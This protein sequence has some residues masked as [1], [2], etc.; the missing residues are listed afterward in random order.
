MASLADMELA[1]GNAETAVRIGRELMALAQGTRAGQ[2]AA[3]ERVNLCAAY[4]AL[5]QVDEALDLAR[6]FWPEAGRLVARDADQIA[7]A[8]REL[9]TAP[10]KREAVAATVDRFSWEA[11]TAGL[12]AHLMRL[13]EIRR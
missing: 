1:A 3:Y 6:R 2:H 13:A 11:N 8:V 4:L 10:S 5:D 12:Y 7:A 9:L